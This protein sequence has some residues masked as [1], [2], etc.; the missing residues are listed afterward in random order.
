M[1]RIVSL[2]IDIGTHIRI[3]YT[4]ECIARST[5][6][7]ITIYPDQCSGLSINLINMMPVLELLSKGRKVVIKISTLK[8][9]E[10]FTL[11]H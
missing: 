6:N 9:M 2:K 7:K 4:M 3:D 5:V 11:L 10:Y 8:Y 1:N